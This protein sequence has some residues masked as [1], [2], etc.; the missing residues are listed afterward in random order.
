MEDKFLGYKLF[1]SFV[2]L[3]QFAFCPKILITWIILGYNTV[4]H[5]KMNSV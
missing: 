2:K 1:F 4:Y 5:I 3:K